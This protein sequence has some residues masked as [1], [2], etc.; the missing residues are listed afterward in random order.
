MPTRGRRDYL[1]DGGTDAVLRLQI[2]QRVVIPPVIFAGRSFDYG[3]DKPAAHHVRASFRGD[4]MIARP[5]LR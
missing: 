3:P 5:I 2:H 1:G 4:G